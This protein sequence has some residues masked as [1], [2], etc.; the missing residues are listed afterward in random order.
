MARAVIHLRFSD[1]ELANSVSESTPP[2]AMEVSK[3]A[4]SIECAAPGEVF[5]SVIISFAV[6]L[7]TSLVANWIFD[8]LKKSGK[9][10]SRINRQQVV[11]HKRDILRLVHKELANQQA[12]DSQ[13]RRKKRKLPK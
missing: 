4:Y 5:I 6:G 13:R 9:K 10:E 8:C 2:E 1:P 11:F 7:P 12:R 3:P